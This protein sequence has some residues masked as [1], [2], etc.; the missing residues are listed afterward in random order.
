MTTVIDSLLSLPCRGLLAAPTSSELVTSLTYDWPRTPLGWT[1]LIGGFVCLVLFVFW[2]YLKDTKQLHWFWRSFLLML[3]LAFIAGLFIIAINPQERTRERVFQKSR[4]AILVDTSL[5]MRHP[6]SEEVETDQEQFGA[7][8]SR[9]EAVQE[10]LLKSPL[11]EN[12]RA[13][14]QVS[15]YTFHG[16]K[17]GPLRIFPLNEMGNEASQRNDSQDSSSTTNENQNPAVDAE[18][19]KT[20]LE[21]DGVK[22]SLGKSVVELIQEVKSDLL[23]GII[24]ISD[25]AY[26]SDLKPEEAH[27]LALETKTRLISLGVG[28]TQEPKLFQIVSMQAPTDVRLGDPYEIQVSLQGQGLKNDT[29][30]SLELLAK[31]ADQNVKPKVVEEVKLKLAGETDQT[32]E[33]ATGLQTAVRHT[34]HVNPEYPGSLKYLVRA[35]P[36][37]EVKGLKEPLQEQEKTINIVKRNTGVLLIA[38]GPCRDYRF[39]RNMLAR[40]PDIDLDVWLQSVDPEIAANVSQESDLFLTEFPSIFPRRNLEDLK[41]FHKMT[42]NDLSKEAK[43]YDV[44]I[45]FDPNWYATGFGSDPLTR[46][47]AVQRL[48]EW[49]DRS[50]GGVV[51]IAGEVYTPEL[52]KNTEPFNPEQYD[53]FDDLKEKQQRFLREF[54][55]NDL[56]PVILEPYFFRPISDAEVMN[57]WPLELTEKGQTADFLQLADTPIE[58]AEDWQEF[59]GIFSCYPTNGYKAGA[60]VYAHFADAGVGGGADLPIFMASQ[61]YGSGR[62]YYVGSPEIWRLRRLSELHF[63]RFWLKIIQEAGQGR[64]KMGSSQTI[65]MME[66]SVVIGQQLRARFRLQDPQGDPILNDEV[67]MKVFLPNG[68][69]LLPSPKLKRH[70]SSIDEP[71]DEYSASFRA[72][73]P[74]EYRLEVLNPTESEPVIVRVQAESPQL[75]DRDRQQN[76]KL[77]TDLVR[78]TGGR[79]YPLHEA[80][81]LEQ[82]VAEKRLNEKET[83]SDASESTAGP[84][85]GEDSSSDNQSQGLRPEMF[86]VKAPSELL[87]NRSKSDWINKQLRTLW[88]RS[89]LM[90]LLIGL[91]CLEW[92]IRKL[93]KLA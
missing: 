29:E 58:S 82:K 16:E 13:N 30:I 89:N 64:R 49:V 52:T 45:L 78:D 51:L 56:Y 65:E 11:L 1:V 9:D 8:L 17:K 90:Y 83:N 70:D 81:S 39:V 14:H 15:L 20:T 46:M 72:E 85:N 80:F 10:F 3:R 42:E 68:D 43:E 75:E 21:P 84:K 23:S 73:M 86:V 93:L 40:H 19:W 18:F 32:D 55:L 92:L 26:N 88:D 44:V 38:G 27:Q 5:S 36:I 48:V 91:L 4:V 61:F 50:S 63:D 31:P 60:T 47:L 54:N 71:S 34:F 53:G 87:P 62:V 67:L 6:Y 41:G 77:L 25:G 59:P 22:T 24:I 28:S 76:A 79:Y 57:P 35:K 74:G 2:L 7:N 66:E 33:E 37:S 12:L 69:P